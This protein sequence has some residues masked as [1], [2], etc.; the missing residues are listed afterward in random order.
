MPPPFPCTVNMMVHADEERKEQYGRSRLQASRATGAG[1]ST[2]T[3]MSDI[4]GLDGAIS[5]LQDMLATV[6]NYVDQ[7]VVRSICM[8]QRHGVFVTTASTRSP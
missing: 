6:S 2:V 8:S 4:A 5:K 7:V 1:S 3:L